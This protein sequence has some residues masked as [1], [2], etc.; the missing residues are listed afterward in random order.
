MVKY[1]V[2]VEEQHHAFRIKES[3][4]ICTNCLWSDRTTSGLVVSILL[5]K[6]LRKESVWGEG[7]FLA[8][9]KKWCV[10]SNS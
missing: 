6:A 5:F 9:M 3:L 10:E 4:Y 2:V 7:K 1:Q 8:R